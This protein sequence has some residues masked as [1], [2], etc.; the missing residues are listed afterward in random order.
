VEPIYIITLGF[1]IAFGGL[2]WLYIQKP[3]S[4]QLRQ[5]NDPHDK[6]E[7]IKNT[8]ISAADGISFSGTASVTV[9]KLRI[10]VD[11]S[12]LPASP[13]PYAWSDR[14]RVLIGEI[15]NVVRQ[16]VITKQLAVR[17]RNGPISDVYWANPSENFPVGQF[18]KV[19][20]V[21]M[22]PEGTEQHHYF[23]LARSGGLPPFRILEHS[24]W[25]IA[26][27]NN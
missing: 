19:R 17:G 27:R 13:P 10:F 3:Q 7:F 22:D 4:I 11:Y 12:F 23:F 15:E 2:V 16:T 9:A 14:V 26:W 5:P 6:I 18:N 20:L 24:D 25:T 21:I 1:V 8:I